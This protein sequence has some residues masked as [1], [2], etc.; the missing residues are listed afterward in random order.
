MRVSLRSAAEPW[1]CGDSWMRGTGEEGHIQSPHIRGGRGN[2]NTRSGCAHTSILGRAP[3]KD[4]MEN[5]RG[6]VRS[7]VHGLS[8]LKRRRTHLLSLTGAAG[9]TEMHRM[10]GPYARRQRQYGKTQRKPAS[11]EFLALCRQQRRAT[12]V[13]KDRIQTVE[14]KTQVKGK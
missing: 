2:V 14:M 3:R 13:S 12:K 7:P 6:Q 9:G 8:S 10:Y 5:K 4:E 11:R 1:Q